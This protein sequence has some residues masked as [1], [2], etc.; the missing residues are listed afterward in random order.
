MASGV[1]V[2]LT[3]K[4][5]GRWTVLERCAE[6]RSS[7]VRWLVMCTCGVTRELDGW[8]VAR[9]MSKACIKCAYKDLVVR[10]RLALSPS[11]LQEKFKRARDTDRQAGRL[12][13]RKRRARIRAELGPAAP[14]LIDL[15]GRSFG[16]WK[17]LAM[18]P[19]IAKRKVH[20]LCQCSCGRLSSVEGCGLRL[21]RT[22]R[23]QTCADVGGRRSGRFVSR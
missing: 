22:R 21:G 8:R 17:V 3:G 6:K 11:E 14:K 23:C 10:R 9:G 15:V 16:E 4:Q 20:W 1:F 18:M 7:C 19:A 2:D 12:Y 5:F 13:A